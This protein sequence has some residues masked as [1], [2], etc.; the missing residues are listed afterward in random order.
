MLYTENSERAGVIAETAMEIMARHAIPANPMNFT[1]WYSYC[2]DTYPELSQALNV[3]LSNNAG[4]SSERNEEIFG[5]YFGCDEEREVLQTT[6]GEMQGKIDEV[7]SHVSQAGA[8][9]SDFGEK[10]SGLTEELVD[11]ATP[12][13][14]ANVVREI[15]LQTQGLVT[16][17]RALEGRLAAASVEITS[18]RDHLKSMRQEALTDSLT[19]L[20]NRKCFDQRL[21][22]EAAKAMEEGTQL[23]LLILDIDHFKKF[24]D[25]F[26]HQ[27]GDSVLKV[28]ARNLN[29]EVKGQ[30]LPA[31]YGGEEFCVILPGTR[32]E[33]AATVAEQI[34]ARLAKRALKNS[35]TDQSYG[36]ITLS[37][38]AALYQ[39]GESITDFVQRA[40]QCLYLA[41]DGG[42]NRVV[43]EAQMR[44]KLTLVG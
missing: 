41:K 43:T 6:S 26:G 12:Q 17:S 38:G 42:R 8:D 27:I 19:G 21:R 14:V 32:L 36:K 4:F 7:I 18:L 5:K 24:N 31:R 9:S 29:D 40:D 39:F 22:E 15:L 35:K 33:D 20:A 34:R 30:D 11:G 3:V 2:A 25:D 37:V 16:R 13:E 10:L 28:V 1:I 44:Q 23:S